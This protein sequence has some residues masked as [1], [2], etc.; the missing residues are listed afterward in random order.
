IPRAIEIPQRNAHLNKCLEKARK[1]TT[2][3]KPTQ[4]WPQTQAQTS[5]PQPP[6]RAGHRVSAHIYWKPSRGTPTAA[7]LLPVRSIQAASRA[8]CTA[9][10]TRFAAESSRDA[11]NQPSF[12]PGEK[13]PTHLSLGRRCDYAG[14]VSSGPLPC[15]PQSSPESARQMP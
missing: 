6:L 1:E 11:A 7:A 10:S 4:R 14:E 5:E 8:S 13:K 3:P 15:E 9:A 12:Q 2:A